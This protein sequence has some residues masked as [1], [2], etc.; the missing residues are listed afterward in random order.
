LQTAK[1]GS[2]NATSSIQAVLS[3]IIR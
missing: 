3:V 1:A 2:K